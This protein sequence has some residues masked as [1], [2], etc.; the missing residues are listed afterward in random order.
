MLGVVVKSQD[1]YSY[2]VKPIG[3]VDGTPVCTPYRGHCMK[4]YGGCCD[5]LEC[6]ELKHDRGSRCLRKE[7]EQDWEMKNQW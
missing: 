3:L 6:R 1:G 7:S 2:C 5:G 4:D